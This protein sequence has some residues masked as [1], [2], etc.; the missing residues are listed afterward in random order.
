MSDFVLKYL[1]FER[2]KETQKQEFH[3]LHE[4][5][6]TTGSLHDIIFSILEKF[7]ELGGNIEFVGY[8]RKIED[9]SLLVSHVK[10]KSCNQLMNV[11]FF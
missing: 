4:M 2:L 11:C 1:D 7:M 5:T 10:E 3:I 8:A 6:D 9:D